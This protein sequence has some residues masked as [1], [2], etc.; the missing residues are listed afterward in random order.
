M[1]CGA[2]GS[3]CK[4]LVQ[5]GVAPRSF[6]ASSERYSVITEGIN[7]IPQHSGRQWGV[8]EIGQTKGARRLKSV[9]YEG[10]IELECSKYNLL[11][12]LPRALWSEQINPPFTSGN[13]PSF[14]EFDVM[15][16]KEVEVFLYRK[17]LV[18]ELVIT[19][20]SSLENSLLRLIINV[21]CM[22]HSFSS[23]WPVVEPP[24][25]N[26]D[27]SMPYTF[28]E[29][30]TL[31]NYSENLPAN[32]VLFAIKNN[33]V[34]VMSQSVTAQKF[35]SLG[36]EVV[37]A[38]DALFN[39]QSLLMIQGAP[40]S[41]FNTYFNISHPVGSVSIDMKNLQ[42]VGMNH[43]TIP[44]NTFLPL[45]FQF[46]AGKPSASNPELAVSIT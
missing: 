36:R 16:N 10:T 44:G 38:G 7:P 42:N 45:P 19:G 6:D 14:H 30:E 32:K 46:K 37:F 1:T 29:T 23:Q 8:G 43:P 18:N 41:S 15:L 33:L 35:R 9:L 27:D 5:G 25:P 4:M 31:L 26:D 2:I 22:E 20:N 13:R 34:P 12:W 11:R 39:Q 28:Y 21:A 17:C 3:L 40:N 24:V